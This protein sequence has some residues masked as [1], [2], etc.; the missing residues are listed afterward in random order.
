WHGLLP[1]T[2][3]A[4]LFEGEEAVPVSPSAIEK[5]LESPL[6]WF[7]ERVAGG[8]SG[9][10]ANVGTIVHWAMETVAEPSPAAL[11]AAVESR[12][13]EL[14]FEAPW[15]A[16][17]QQQ[18]VRGFTDALAEYLDDFTSGGKTLVGAE[19]RFELAVGR[20]LL[21][22]SIDRV[23]RDGEGAVVIVDL[24]TGTPITRQS[25]IDAHP[26]LGA[27]QLAYAEGI[28]NEA[29]AAHGEHSSGGAKL[30]YV[31]EG[32]G[33]KRYREAIQAAMTPEQL[34]AF[35]E[36]VSAAAL[37]IAAAEFAGTLELPGYGMD[38]SRLRLHRVRAV[39]SD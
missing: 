18:I 2:S 33:S 17:R 24:K 34:E 20:A 14:V 37:L 26:Q 7:L 21:R 8:D 5:L 3:V 15:L 19:S 35:R 32:V 23:E 39:S 16:S 27:Y 25:D 31:K 11:W 12:W 22:G 29:L 4:P 28:L 38:T 1:P 10:Y 13:D 9:I 6:D 36:R 30:L